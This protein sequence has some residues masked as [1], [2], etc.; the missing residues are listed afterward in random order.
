MGGILA[1]FGRVWP[2]LA[3]F[4]RDLAAFFSLLAAFG[5]I[6][7]AVPGTGIAGDQG[8]C[9]LGKYRYEWPTEVP[10]NTG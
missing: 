1:A 5:R 4:G 7:T 3:A 10:R 2:R 6:L 8:R 9:I